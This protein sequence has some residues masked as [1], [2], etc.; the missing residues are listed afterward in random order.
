[1][2]MYDKFGT[3]QCLGWGI[4]TDF[5]VTWWYRWVESKELVTTVMFKRLAKELST[6]H[7]FFCMN[8]WLFYLKWVESVA[9]PELGHTGTPPSPFQ[10]V[11]S[12]S[13]KTVS[14]E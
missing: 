13:K 4:M 12:P 7:L 5:M 9:F 14:S 3:L 10:V 2:V 11:S 6:W 1:M 8:P